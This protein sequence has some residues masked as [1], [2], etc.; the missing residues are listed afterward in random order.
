MKKILIY[1]FSGIFIFVFGF[2]VGSFWTTLK[3]TSISVFGKS[4]IGEKELKEYSDFPSPETA[5]WENKFFG[6]MWEREDR[7]KPVPDGEGY[8]R[9][10]FIYEGKPT[11][12]IKFKMFL[13]SKYKTDFIKTDENGSFTIRLPL[14]EWY[15]NS[16]QCQEWKNRPEGSFILLSGDEKKID[17]GPLEDLFFSHS[18]KGKEVIIAN[19]KPKKEHIILTIKPRIK[20]TWPEKDMKNQEATIS[21]SKISWQ[22]YPG[23]KDYAI[24][25]DRVTRESPKSSTF[26]PIIYKKVSGESSLKF[27]SLPYIRDTAAK[28]EYAV[29]VSAYGQHGEFLSES[30]HLSG[31]FSLKDGNVLVEIKDR[32]IEASDKGKIE[33]IYQDTKLFNTIETLIKEKMFGEAEILIKKIGENKMPGKKELLTGYL[34]AAKGNCGKAQKFFTTAKQ[35]GQDCIP[36]EYRLNCK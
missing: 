2:L 6:G 19:E 23:V 9:G 4:V 12:W 34:Y 31:T 24:R 18:D 33:Q 22:P 29:T 3:I 16:I 7:L 20:I 14:G 30:E 35:K 25:I 17:K 11:A 32:G 10:K 27:S 5:F 15:I 36:E 26:T 1:I 21:G 13:N 8:L 28:E